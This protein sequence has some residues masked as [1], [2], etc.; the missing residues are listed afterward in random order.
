VGESPRPLRLGGAAESSEGW[1]LEGGVRLVVEEFV[2]GLLVELSPLRIASACPLTC[3]PPG[4][5]DCQAFA[6]GI[7]GGCASVVTGF[8]FRERDRESERSS[9]GLRL[10]RTLDK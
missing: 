5:C 9:S 10:F 4:D 7:G 6:A 1:S 3:A 2:F 8:P